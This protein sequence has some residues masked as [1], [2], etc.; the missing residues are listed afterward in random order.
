MFVARGF[1]D[2]VGG[3]GSSLSRSASADWPGRE[4]RFGE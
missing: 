2:Q 1:V 3:G 4:S